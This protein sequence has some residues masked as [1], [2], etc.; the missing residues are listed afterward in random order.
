M[1]NLVKPFKGGN[2][3]YKW[4]KND[5]LVA[6]TTSDDWPD[7]Q[8]LEPGDKIAVKISNKYGEILTN[9]IQVQA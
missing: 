6:T 9:T 7:G 1:R 3:T 8:E 5:E 4:Y 2:F